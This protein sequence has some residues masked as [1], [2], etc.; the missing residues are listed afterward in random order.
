MTHACSAGG[1]RHPAVLAATIGL[2]L[3]L[4]LAIAHG[5]GPQ[6]RKA[7]E[8]HGPIHVPLPE[9]QP[10]PAK[11]HVPGDPLPMEPFYLPVP[12]PVLKYP[13][14][15]EQESAPTGQ[16]ASGA[17]PGGSIAVIPGTG[18]Y[19]P[20][21][22]RTRR[23]RLNALI[24]SCYPAAARRENEEGKGL[25][26]IVIDARGSAASWSVAESSGYVRLDIAMDCVI[27]CLTFEPARR[28]GAA[29]ASE[30]QL[31]IVFRLD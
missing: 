10:E 7:I 31:P 21:S 17:A 30:V 26:H 16:P 8:D 11:R 28:D 6:I 23:D 9:P 14:F 27:R 18:K 19:V 1:L 4:F 24:D 13:D 29:V 15:A 25:A 20:A 2:H 22:L 5:L 12:E 3:G